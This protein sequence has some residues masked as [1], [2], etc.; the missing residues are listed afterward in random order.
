M[1]QI[2]GGKISAK[3]LIEGFQTDRKII[4]EDIRFKVMP[5]SPPGPVT[6]VRSGYLFKKKQGKSI[7][8]TW[9]RIYATIQEGAFSYCSIGKVRGQIIQS[10]QINVLLCEVKVADSVERRFCFEINSA[11]RYFI[12]QAESDIELKAWL[13][14]FEAAK[15]EALAMRPPIGPSFDSLDINGLKDG[16]EGKQRRNAVLPEYSAAA[17]SNSKKDAVLIHKTA[18]LSFSTMKDMLPLTSEAES[19]L[20]LRSFNSNPSNNSS[21]NCSFQYNDAVF[22]KYNSDL[23]EQLPGLDPLEFVLSVIPCAL[24]KEISLQGRLYLTQSKFYFYS[25]IFGRVTLIPISYRDVI[26]LQ[27]Y[28][29]NYYSTI[30]IHCKESRYTFK[31]FILDDTKTIDA[32]NLFC[33]NDFQEN[34][35][36]LSE[37]FQKVRSSQSEYLLEDRM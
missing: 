13:D 1:R 5:D 9:R 22:E 37:L 21:G 15:K 4:E 34:P 11:K 24:Q 32:F 7:V 17:N 8:P 27:K 31:T 16:S 26:S 18:P 10:N 28:E 20:R 25:N 36:S 6:A 19:L 14:S 23:H 3:T 2:E 33:K 30:K 12:F 29:Y 35:L